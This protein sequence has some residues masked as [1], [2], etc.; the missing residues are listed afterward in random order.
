[1]PLFP[2]KTQSA[3]FLFLEDFV[4]ISF[5]SY[6]HV[7]LVVYLLLKDRMEETHKHVRENVKGAM[8]RQ[9]KYYDQKRSWQ[10]FQPGDQVFI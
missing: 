5:L 3:H 9:K 4:D 6:P 8:H 1:L 2:R 10:S 7:L